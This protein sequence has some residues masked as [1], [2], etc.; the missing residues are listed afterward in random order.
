MEPAQVMNALPLIYVA[1]LFITIGG[2]I[3]L[4]RISGDININGAVIL[5]CA[6]LWFIAVPL[7]LVA[8]LFAFVAVVIEELIDYN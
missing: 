7:I 6:L 2:G 3:T 1:G 5:T 8:F 4:A